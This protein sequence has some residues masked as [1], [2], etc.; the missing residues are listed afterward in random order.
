MIQLCISGSFLAIIKNGVAT[1]V[2]AISHIYDIIV[3]KEKEVD[4]VLQLKVTL[5]IVT[6]HC[7]YQIYHHTV[8]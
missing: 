8:I 3:V 2:I 5:H 7:A 1:R 4:G 6:D